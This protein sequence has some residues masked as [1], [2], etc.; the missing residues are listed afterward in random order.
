[1]TPAD[2]GIPSRRP[3]QNDG[4]CIVRAGNEVASLLVKNFI[5]DANPDQR[6]RRRQSH[7]GA[8]Y[9]AMTWAKL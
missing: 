3:P 6:R 9:P 1:M 5:Q 7:L 4:R 8:L 2:P